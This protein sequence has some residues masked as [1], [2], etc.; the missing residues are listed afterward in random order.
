M[1]LQE[2]SL[3]AD[4]ARTP[5]PVSGNEVRACNSGWQ[6]H[7]LGQCLCCEQSVR[8]RL[9]R[10]RRTIAPARTKNDAFL[11]A[12][13]SASHGVRHCSSWKQVQ[14]GAMG[15]PLPDPL[16]QARDLIR[17][18]GGTE[19]KAVSACE[20]VKTPRSMGRWT[21]Y[22]PERG[23]RLWHSGSPGSRCLATTKPRAPGPHSVDGHVH[24][25][26]GFCRLLPWAIRSARIAARDDIRKRGSVAIHQA[27][28]NLVEP[29]PH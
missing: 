26:L 24:R 20:L 12:L 16:P 23:T 2:S 19:A 29:K 14:D 5:S 3:H 8:G 1:G 25:R 21:G 6:G 28:S 4:S 27:L 9:S 15:R 10:E 22:P 7:V 18:A 17:F 11:G 13:Q